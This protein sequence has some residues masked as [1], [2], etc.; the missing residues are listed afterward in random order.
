MSLYRASHLLNIVTTSY[1]IPNIARA[2]T[3]ASTRARACAR[4][5]A[6]SW[7]LE[8]ARLSARCPGE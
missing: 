3:R 2:R 6:R 8:R 1:L 4:T 7:K 5:A